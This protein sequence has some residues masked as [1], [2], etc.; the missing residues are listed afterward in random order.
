MSNDVWRLDAVE[1]YALT[2]LLTWCLFPPWWR[3]FRQI[4]QAAGPGQGGKAAA[5]IWRTL[6]SEELDRL[7]LILARIITMR[8]TGRL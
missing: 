7:E 4:T 1:Y 5:K 6:P 3:V 8:E 2:E